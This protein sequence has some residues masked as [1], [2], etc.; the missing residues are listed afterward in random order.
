MSNLIVPDESK[1]PNLS[2]LAGVGDSYYE[3]MLYKNNPAVG[4]ASVLGDFVECDFS[5]YTRGALTTPTVSGT[6]DVL[7]RGFVTWDVLTWTKSGATGNTVYGYLL[8]SLAGIMLAVERFD[9]GIPLTAD[10]AFITMT[11]KLTDASQ[12]S[13]T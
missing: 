8:L 6:L 12:Y 1:A 7:G 10:G 2:I 9:A 4:H 3:V 13:N 5:G 11:P